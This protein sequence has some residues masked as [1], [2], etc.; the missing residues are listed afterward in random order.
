MRAIRIFP[1]GAR[2]VAG[3]DHEEI[4]V[5][6][7]DELHRWAEHLCNGQVPDA[8]DLLQDAFIEFMRR[9]PPLDAIQNP[10]A[11]LRTMLRNLHVSGIRR[12][13]TLKRGTRSLV[14]FD[15]LELAVA[16]VDP[17]SAWDRRVEL[18]LLCGYICDRKEVSK[19]AS[20]LIL[21]FFHD[22]LPSEIALLMRSNRRAVDEWLR[23]AR[24][25]AH[26]FL[27]N[28]ANG[29][30]VT[31][32][33]DS[34]A[35]TDLAQQVRQTVFRH[36]SGDCLSPAE[37]TALYAPSRLEPLGH[38]VLAHLVSCPTCLKAASEA[39][40]IASP[41]DRTPP[42]EG[43][44]SGAT[45]INRPPA[46]RDHLRATLRRALQRSR[47]QRPT[48]LVIAAN[49]FE[50]S[51]QVLQPGHNQHS[52][53]PNIGAEIGFV[54][55]FSETGARLIYLEI[56]PPPDGPLEQSADVE[57]SDGRRVSLRVRFDQ[58]WPEIQA[59]YDDPELE[60]LAP[61]E[62]PAPPRRTGWLHRFRA[63]WR[64]AF[65][66]A[67]LLLIAV[68]SVL[69]TTRR[70]VRPQPITAATLVRDAE[71]REQA[72]TANK[73]GVVHRVLELEDRA[74]G[75][76]RYRIETWTD[77]R[78][79]AEARRVY[80]EHGVLVAG[81]WSSGAAGLHTL[82]RRGA[83]PEFTVEPA[84]FDDTAYTIQRVSTTPWRFSPSPAA[85]RALIAASLQRATVVETT[86]DGEPVYLVEVHPTGDPLRSAILV[87][88]KA[89]LHPRELILLLRTASGIHEYRYRERGFTLVDRSRVPDV[90]L[91]LART[92]R[93]RHS[94]PLDEPP[95]LPAQ[96]SPVEL[97]AEAWYRMHQAGACNGEQTGIGWQPGGL[98]E[99][100]AVVADESRKQALTEALAPLG[101][102][103]PLDVS[104]QVIDSD[105]TPGPSRRATTASTRQQTASQMAAYP[106]LRAYFSRQTGPD[107]ALEARILDF[108]DAVVTSSDRALAQAWSL[109][110]LSEWMGSQRL[111]GRS[112]VWAEQMLRDHARDFR[113]SSAALRTLLETV[114]PAPP[115]TPAAAPD[116][117]LLE[118]AR[119]L[120]KTV[121]AQ[122]AAVHAAFV[123]GPAGSPAAIPDA[124]W[125]ASLLT[126]ERR[127][128]WMEQ[129]G[130]DQALASAHRR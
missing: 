13:N 29:T 33:L 47:E 112:R 42:P 28:P 110:R 118:N 7:Y 75:V 86:R 39:A 109:A 43:R 45:P 36:V 24:A 97:E 40:G 27:Q 2:N 52:V 41:D 90:F 99:I 116:A 101:E 105:D 69:W 125:P 104:I 70:G 15:C 129:H 59:A 94:L 71:A 53:R 25:E 5:S 57:L 98:L 58:P 130:L 14:D 96:P 49:G 102:K 119:A 120:L 128:L 23:L 73:D 89:D 20:V 6:L 32:N 55:L 54:E 95:I 61:A 12:G 66:F 124:S 100:R 19:S 77:T 88:A 48:A 84:P 22:Y 65:A 79:P 92:T 123:P 106:L 44:D 127:A 103:A 60:A 46:S 91:P 21:R 111:E 74:A 121:S 10:S 93:P 107:A 67:C 76:Q 108:A 81:E 38:Q 64:P 1:F 83:R 78:R 17:R 16:G 63:H 62:P 30:V 82:Y 8:E 4:F 126:L 117:G 85:F 37:L 11:Y 51:S 31:L 34:P 50:V 35:G 113:Q 26:R 56:Q 18:E 115:P 3:G 80:D 87:L 114:L 68:A 72:L 9:R 122:N